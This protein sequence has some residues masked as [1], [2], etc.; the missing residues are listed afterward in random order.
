MTAT[1]ATTSPPTADAPDLGVIGL[2]GVE[3]SQ[4][5][6]WVEDGEHVF[7]STEYDVIGADLD[8]NRAVVKF[9]EN[10]EDYARFIADR[11]KEND[12]S[13]DEAE[14]ALTLIQRFAEVYQR[15]RDS[16]QEDA[17]RLIR[18]PRRRRG[19]RVQGGF[20]RSRHA[21]SSQPS[22]V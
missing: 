16:A 11:F 2:G 21:K 20:R 22:P 7:R 18:I 1:A 12:A 17:R 4:V 8:F 15:Q 5:A 19:A 10:S 9:I 3:I 14:V 13:I 6:Y